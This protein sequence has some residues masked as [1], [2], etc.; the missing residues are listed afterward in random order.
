MGGG[1]TPYEIPDWR[2]YK[3]GDHT[4]STIHYGPA[5]TTLFLQPEL[6][7]L[8]RKLAAKGLKDPWIRN[9]AWRYDVRTYGTKKSRAITLLT[10]GMLPGLGLAIICSCYTYWSEAQ[11]KKTH[12]GH[13]H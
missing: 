2:T 5:Y 4:V 12:G 7:K 11:Y 13:H 10:R 6:Q 1:G 8:E 9:I 3:V